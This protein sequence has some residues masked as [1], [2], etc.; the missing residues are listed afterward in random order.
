MPGNP[1]GGAGTP[2]PGD[3][4]ASPRPRAPFGILVE[5]GLPVGPGQ[6]GRSAFLATLT[7]SVTRAAEEELAP[8]GRTTRDCPYLA[9]WLA[10]YRQRPAEAIERA[11]ERYARPGRTDAASLTDA[12]VARVRA[13][14]REWGRSGNI[15]QVPLGVAWLGTTDGVGEPSPSL[16]AMAPAAVPSASGEA[17]AVLARLGPGRPLDLG[18]RTPL[19]RGFGQS[20]ADVRIHTDR[21]ADEVTRGYSAWALTVGRDVAFGAGQF[22][23]GTI[24]GDLLLAHELAHVVQQRG[25]SR[26]PAPKRLET[27]PA[28]S[29]E[30]DAD[31]AAVGVV[32]STWPVGLQEE[33]LRK[34]GLAHDAAKLTTLAETEARPTLTSGLRL[35]RCLGEDTEAPTTDG[36]LRAPAVPRTSETFQTGNVPGQVDPGTALTTGGLEFRFDADGDQM[37]EMQARIRWLDDGSRT[38]VVDV[39]QL[40]SGVTRTVRFQILDLNITGARPHIQ[41]VTDGR[42][43]TRIR[44]PS[45]SSGFQDLL[46]D[47]VERTDHGIRLHAR[48]EQRSLN[49]SPWGDPPQPQSV[50]FPAETT[51]TRR[52]FGVDRN[53]LDQP[54][55][56]QHVGDLWFIDASVGAYN[57]RFR[58]TFRKRNPTQEAVDCSVAVLS[59][60]TPVGGRGFTTFVQ[61]ALNV[62]IVD[63]NGVRL[64]IDLNG[65]GTEE[66]E[67]FDR[68]QAPEGES[69]AERRNHDL[70]ITGRRISYGPQSFTFEV[71]GGQITAG[72][73]SRDASAMLGA[74]LPQA[75]TGLAQEQR[76]GSLRGEFTAQGD[77]INM[78]EYASIELMLTR[79]RTEARDAGLLSRAT[80]DAWVL[81]SQDFVA[82]EAQNRAGSVSDSL[83]ESAARHATDFY[84]AFATETD[85]TIHRRNGGPGGWR[86]V[87]DY[88][89]YERVRNQAPPTTPG[90]DLVAAIRAGQWATAIQKYRTLI[91]GLDRWVADR[92]R[93]RHGEEDASRPDTLR[94][95]QVEYLIN[96]RTAL[97]DI[98]Q[99]NPT[100]V[101]AVFHPEA[102]FVSSGLISETQLSLYY[103]QQDG[104]WRLQD[105][106]NP[107]E[108]LHKDAPI[109]AGETEPPDSLFQRLEEGTHF[110]RG[111]IHYVLP[112][113]RQ[114]QVQT[115][116]PSEWR[117]ILTWAGIGL[118]AIGL[119][120]VTFGQ[121]TIAVLGAAA[122]GGSAIIGG[123]MA[124]FDLYQRATEGTLTGTQAV[125]DIA[126]IIA[127]VSGLG[128]LR[129]GMLVRG[130][131]IAAAEGAPLTG[132]AALLASWASRL[133]IPLA[134]TNLA[135]DVVTLAVLTPELVET[136]RSIDERVA[137]PRERARAK[138][139]LLMQAA[140]TLGLTALS[141][142]GN[143][144]E[145]TLGRNIRIDVVDN[146]PY[147]I[148]EGTS[149]VGQRISQSR[150]T[151]DPGSTEGG[152]FTGAREHS[153]RIRSEVG[154]RG[155]EALS[156]VDQLALRTAWRS[157][158][159]RRILE[160]LRQALTS[161]PAGPEREALARFLQEADAI[162]GNSL[163]SPSQ[164]QAGLRARLTALESANPGLRA[165]VD[166]AAA[167][168]RIGGIGAE[169]AAG[170]FV[171]DTRGNLTTG[172]QGAGTLETLTTQ[173]ARANNAARAHGMETEY[174]LQVR[175]GDAPGTSYV[176]IV[177]RP[178]RGTATADD[179]L[180]PPARAPAE[181]EAGRVG[182]ASSEIVALMQADP[183]S[184][185]SL[186][187]NGTLSINGQIEI[188]PTRLAEIRAARASDVTD[189]LVATRELDAAG[190]EFANVPAASQEILKRL[191]ATQTET[192]VGRYRL[193]FR[194]QRAEVVRLIGE[195]G[196]GGHSL[197]QNLDDA[198]M[199]R[200]FELI[201]EQPPKGTTDF[202]RM[203]A[204]Y[205]LNRQPPPRTVQ[206]FVEYY[207]FFHQEFAL[208]AEGA[209]LAFQERVTARLDAD[210]A[211]W[212]SLPEAERAA[213]FPRGRP[214]RDRVQ[215]ALAQEEG[216]T[217]SNAAFNTRL[218]TE[219][220]GTR[221]AQGGGTE[222]NPAVTSTPARESMSAAYE[223][224]RG[225]LA[226]RVGARRL[227]LHPG[228]DVRGLPPEEVIRRV[229][230]MARPGGPGVH[231]TSE[232]AAVYHA[233][234]HYTQLHA[235][236]Q[237]ATAVGSARGPQEIGPYLDSLRE[238]IANPAR[239]APSGG[240]APQAVTSIA[241][242]SGNGRVYTFTRDVQP[243]GAPSVQTMRALVVVTDDGNVMVLT[244]MGVSGR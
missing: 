57:D 32:A 23:P 185:V 187:P 215:A 87:N 171:L 226:G 172:G 46:I 65:D 201:A 234:K 184:R 62:R 214:S 244:Y 13:A 122:L 74:S 114:G 25:A 24:E 98:E 182:T 120:L 167:A 132:S 243:P 103:W 188:H 16:Q 76:V 8:F 89:G 218:Q 54:S 64:A 202:R 149:A 150:P 137:D 159:Q 224:M 233:H 33:A 15:T 38:V 4:G 104:E 130:A 180:S 115:T 208:R 6:V 141:V 110:P 175:P 138:H 163:L 83:K 2:P 153:A 18:V 52:V 60:G 77:L 143:V 61:G 118:A 101:S 71:A 238:T 30:R 113:G 152:F 128:A 47:P 56:P 96:L 142:R 165:G 193:R 41:E 78:G 217:V 200:L 148:P 53:E 26:P 203:A 59:G 147:A 125:L 1:P 117:S 195:M 240:T 207:Q 66:L 205:A 82:I 209:R 3:P 222:P 91:N 177:A 92:N 135:T 154:G 79:F 108:M 95:R 14:A 126:Q 229:R 227:P 43:P 72:A 189:L 198:G 230:Q 75:A 111:L 20:F 50:E 49:G 119:G 212:N 109:G 93:Q 27:G 133:V 81:L 40:S 156:L 166:F 85:P 158:E 223:A 151:I 219:L 139:L 11:I 160:P 37:K 231:F 42:R 12:V 63:A 31:R 84:A 5:D 123:G 178:R 191:A 51:P 236:E 239:I 73:A 192:T 179:Y 107:S 17:G 146:V 145:L 168:T 237:T 216:I 88:T 169:G 112:S 28:P 10:F 80:Y 206:Q 131:T 69:P 174:V 176:E 86:M 241:N 97:R 39:T 7:E 94:G 173:V 232:S 161:L 155:G 235:S 157:E 99:H 242:Q 170:S 36:R 129:A 162:F 29:L 70:L 144:A 220:A 121:G 68:M 210:L 194:F 48:L 45:T 140:F 34:H 221:P 183:T 55:P 44:F 228:E 134:A 181:A 124:A 100:R 164:K 127:A 22:R 211:R 213:A 190:G 105:M 196:V 21:A 106:T 186:L 35:S 136:F 58:F 197:F 116:G 204:D 90:E 67:L 19:E 9:H 199:F 225:M 102:P